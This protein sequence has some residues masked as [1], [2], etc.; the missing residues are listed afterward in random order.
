MLSLEQRQSFV[1]A[2]KA[3]RQS[4]SMGMIRDS[5]D[6]I[7]KALMVE[8]AYHAAGRMEG[9]YQDRFAHVGLTGMSPSEIINQQPAH[10]MNKASDKEILDKYQTHINSYFKA[11]RDKHKEDFRNRYSL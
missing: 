11:Q 10:L 2:L 7:K 9:T 6:P 5:E 3:Q 8:S 1:S 4:P